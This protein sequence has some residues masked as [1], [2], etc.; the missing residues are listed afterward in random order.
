M[1][2]L[3]HMH[4]TDD[5]QV[6]AHQSTKESVADLIDLYDRLNDCY[7]AYTVNISAHETPLS[8]SLLTPSKQVL[9]DFYESPPTKLKK[10]IRDRRN[11][12]NLDCCPYCGCPNKPDTLDHFIPKDDWP[13]YS[14]YPNNLIPQCGGCAPIKGKFYFCNA[15]RSVLFLHPIY[16]NL[17]SKV[18]FSVEINLADDN[19]A[20]TFTPR[21]HIEDISEPDKR[22]VAIHLIK[23]QT[24]RR[25]IEY[26][27]TE[28]I[29]WRNLR[30]RSAFS[31]E[32]AMN[33]RIIEKSP[34][35]ISAQDWG[36]ALYIG[37]ISNPQ[38][39]DYFNRIKSHTTKTVTSLRVEITI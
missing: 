26:C 17:L 2:S 36:T 34:D 16:T 10:L 27:E 3:A 4:L 14:I 37:I 21:F 5:W 38:I 25:F 9:V 6:I 22:R 30:R 39:V 12:H 32:D 28:F 15:Q 8:A 24:K 19:S 11:K 1:E 35:R 7:A 31:I 18:F 20:P 13:E 23:L 29:I 33:Q